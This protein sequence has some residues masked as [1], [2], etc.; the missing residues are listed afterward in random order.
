MM[1]QMESWQCIFTGFP[2]R[3]QTN[4]FTYWAPTTHLQLSNGDTNS[5]QLSP[6][7]RKYELRMTQLGLNAYL[8]GRNK[9]AISKG[10]NRAPVPIL[11]GTTTG[12]FLKGSHMCTQMRHRRAWVTVGAK[13]IWRPSDPS[14]PTWTWARRL[15][16]GRQAGAPIRSHE[17]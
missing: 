9:Q 11:G 7:G 16:A 8:E 3:S 12:T 5:A 14:H 6:S 15:L 1:N 13:G 2:N 17:D 4:F 10:K